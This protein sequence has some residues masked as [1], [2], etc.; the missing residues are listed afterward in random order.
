MDPAC[1]LG[2]CFFAS[3]IRAFDNFSKNTP[4]RKNE[5]SLPKMNS[6]E[7]FQI[8]PNQPGQKRCTNWHTKTKSAPQGASLLA[9]WRWGSN[10]S[11][12]ALVQTVLALANFCGKI[13]KLALLRRIVTV[14]GNL[15]TGILAVSSFES[16]P[17]KHCLRTTYHAFLREIIK[18]LLN[19]LQYQLGT[20]RSFLNVEC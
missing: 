5:A 19:Q 1:A 6:I 18:H 12:T 15:S 13:R 4:G 14:E 2:L 11:K 17:R 9:T 16:Q 20:L 10:R 7:I 8:K 3:A